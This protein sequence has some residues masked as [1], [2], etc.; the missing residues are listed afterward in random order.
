[1]SH[2]RQCWH[3]SPNRRSGPVALGAAEDPE[4]SPVWCPPSWLGRWQPCRC[5][6]TRG[7]GKAIRPVTEHSED[8]AC[9]YEAIKTVAGQVGMNPETLRKWLRQA[10]TDAGVRD[11]TTTD[12]A[13]DGRSLPR[14]P[15]YRPR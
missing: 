12:S 11:G 5:S 6:T 1:M 13:R 15:R 3:P 7:P 8:Y 9:E 2:P 14:R 10:E 4:P